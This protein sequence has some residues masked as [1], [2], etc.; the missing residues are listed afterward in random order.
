MLAVFRW[1]IVILITA[2]NILL[3]Y[4]YLPVAYFSCLQKYDKTESNFIAKTFCKNRKHPLLVGSVKSNIGMSDACGPYVGL[5][6][7]IFA[8]ESGTIVQN[9][10]LNEINDQIE[11]FASNKLKA[12]L[13]KGTYLFFRNK[14]YYVDFAT[15]NETT[16]MN[17]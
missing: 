13:I 9:M 16:L 8:L 3:T 2:D 15:Y 7:A 12:S 5:I 11:A 1:D 4:Y 10:N 17:T 14:M 6:K